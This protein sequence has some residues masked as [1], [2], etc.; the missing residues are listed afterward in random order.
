MCD[1]SRRI[2]VEARAVVFVLCACQNSW[3]SL[4]Q[5]LPS[6]T[7]FKGAARSIQS[8]SRISGPRGVDSSL[9]FPLS[10]FAKLW[11]KRCVELGCTKNW[12]LPS[13]NHSRLL[14]WGSPLGHGVDP[15]IGAH[16]IGPTGHWV[17]WT[18]KRCPYDHVLGLSSCLRVSK[19]VVVK[20]MVTA[21]LSRSI[22][23]LSVCLSVRL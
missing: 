16:P 5:E 6:H 10:P 19:R 1:W 21:T 4:L 17:W 8:L 22:T 20:S 14:C 9:R 7:V 3:N 13:I 18:I 15:V 2:Y 11:D 12:H 23:R